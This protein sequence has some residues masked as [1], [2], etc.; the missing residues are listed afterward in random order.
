[1]NAS[2]ITFGVELEVTLPRE[3]F[4]EV[5]LRV[6]GYHAGIQVPGL[7]VGWNAQSD[8][9]IDAKRGY[10]GVEIVSPVLKGTDGLKQVAE[11]CRWL[12]SKRAEV[13]RSTGFHVH[14]GF[15]RND[16]DGLKRLVTMV[17]NHEKAL[18]AS[19]GTHSREQGAY[20]KSV[21]NDM[22]YR[23]EFKDGAGRA[24]LERYHVLNLKN[25]RT[26]GGKPT[27]E[28]RVFAGTINPVKTL[29]YV[30]L[31]LGLVEKAT[32]VRKAGKW[33]AKTPKETS[34]IHRSGEGQ[35]ALTRLFYFLGWTRG[36]ESYTFGGLEDADLPT[37][38]SAKHELMRLA[39]KYD[40]PEEAE[41]PAT[42]TATPASAGPGP[43][44]GQRVRH[45]SNTGSRLGTI[46]ADMGQGRVQVRFDDGTF[47]VVPANSLEQLI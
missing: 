18:F 4:G 36:R 25:L 30:R 6:G 39:K 44:V 46:D 21:Q 31:C 3:V 34:P 47:S 19:T 7:P 33:V 2:E 26:P 32:K 12:Q 43:L 24:D 10:S 8:C 38:K 11:V 9:S 28:F 16:Q 17:A 15:D 37:I 1:M 23:R 42:A 13:N 22:R 40:G 41:T 20:C 27:V 5:G 14:C 35:T 29:A 45:V